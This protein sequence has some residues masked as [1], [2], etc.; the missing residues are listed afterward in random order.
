MIKPQRLKAGDKI[1]IVSLSS[2][3][4]GET[5][6]AHE[7]ELGEKRLKEF[8]LQPVYTP[9]AKKGIAYIKDHPEA[10]AADL[11]QAFKDP[12]IKGIVCA[13]GGDDTFK[14]IPYLLDDPEF[15]ETVKN[16]PKVFLGYSDTTNNHLMFYKLGLQ[17]YY[18]QAFLTDL[19][20]LADDMLPYSKEW[21]EELLFPSQA[22]EIKPSPVWYEEREGFGPE[23]VSVE[24]VSHPESRGF[25][26][27][28]GT[29]M[30]T[31]ELLGGCIE[32]LYDQLIGERYAAEKTIIKKYG[33]FPSKEE[34]RGKIL[35][36]ETS[37]EKP[38]PDKLHTMLQALGEAGVF[39][40][41]RA[42][43]IGKPQDEQFY[44]EYKDVWLE[45]TAKWHTPILYNLNFGH[46]T[47]H[48]ILPY[49]GKV[50]IDLDGPKVFLKEPLVAG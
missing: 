34:W 23:Q 32:S 19:A 1:A 8:G 9:N 21:F 50:E 10:R 18:G 3:V 27:L 47:P 33:I 43:I 4:L 13:V 39:E 41:I 29:G 17:T 16:N 20:E 36:A 14:T 37:E 40:N 42:V 22:K 11:K 45:S 12:A 26:V 28:R 35:F 24:R 15:V 30:V 2:G 38:T 25:E 31:G 7:L 46:A 6:A 44:E 48:C 49:G 5:F